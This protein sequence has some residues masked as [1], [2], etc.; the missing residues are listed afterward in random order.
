MMHAMSKVAYSPTEEKLLGLLPPRGG[1]ITSEELAEKLYPPGE[2]PFNARASVRA[3]M[4]NLIRKVEHN[5][6]DF[7]IA[8]ADRSGPNPMSYWKEKA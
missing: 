2:A 6:E 7:R 1:P 8:Q 4:K 3:M 5:K